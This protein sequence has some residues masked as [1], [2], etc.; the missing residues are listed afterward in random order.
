MPERR[1]LIVRGGGLGEQLV[2]LGDLASASPK[3]L[4]AIDPFF[5]PAPLDAVL[6]L[7]QLLVQTSKVQG[8]GLKRL[9]HHAR[10]LLAGLPVAAA[11]GRRAE[12]IATDSRFNIIIERR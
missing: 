12:V 2:A 10:V 11:E 7:A 4:I 5:R 9:V 1:A 6:G 8:Q 3:V